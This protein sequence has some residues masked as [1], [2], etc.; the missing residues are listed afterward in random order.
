M[1]P[2]SLLNEASTDVKDKLCMYYYYC[3]VLAVYL[4]S[5]FYSVLYCPIEPNVHKIEP[6][7]TFTDPDWL[8]QSD[9]SAN[10][11]QTVKA[12]GNLSVSQTDF[13]S[14]TFTLLGV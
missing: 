13:G 2:S 3:L 8:S 12:Y 11:V 1:T 7:H 14:V 9:Q 6:E 5:M 4:S 10:S